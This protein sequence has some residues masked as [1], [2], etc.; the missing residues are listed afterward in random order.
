MAARRL[1]AILV[2]LLLISTFAAALAPVREDDST[3]STTTTQPADPTDPAGAGA[4]GGLVKVSIPADEGGGSGAQEAPIVDL[5]PGDRLAL[6]VSPESPGLV[7]LR[8]LGLSEYADGITPARF[9]VLL[10]S[11]GRYPVTLDGEQIGTIK[12]SNE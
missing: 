4:R 2:V 6:T 5:Q 1:L 9:D 8:D 12:V 10:R 7:E 3:T 11:A